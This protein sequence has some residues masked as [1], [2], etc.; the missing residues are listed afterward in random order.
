VLAIRRQ[1][2]WRRKGDHGHDGIAELSDLIAHGEHMFLARQSSE[3]AMQN[4]HH[5]SPAMVLDSPLLAV[6]VNQG[7]VWKQVTYTDLCHH[8][9][10][11]MANW[12]RM[13]TMLDLRLRALKN[14][15]LVPLA[16]PIG[17]LVHPNAITALSLVACVGAAVLAALGHRSSA[18][19]LWLIGR[20]LDG[21]D[22]LVARDRNQQS[23]LGGYLDMMADTVGYAAIPI[24][25]AAHQGDTRAWAMCALLLASFYINTMSWTYLSAIAEKRSVGAEHRG[26]V[27]TI[28]MPSGLI[29]GTE[30]IVLFAV[31]LA[32]PVHV[33]VWFPVMAAL[34]MLTVLQRLAWAFRHVRQ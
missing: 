8:K 9:L 31:M 21:I 22:G 6:V 1:T 12:E 3:V 28:H 18:V 10:E 15:A 19:A 17:H 33:V 4:Q 7:N 24:G 14:R 20:G 23:D 29:E 30:T 16:R 13:E 32:W 25:L 5:R 11:A 26:E 27:T 2:F 34:V